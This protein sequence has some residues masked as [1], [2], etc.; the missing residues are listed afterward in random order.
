[1]IQ[2]SIGTADPER[3]IAAQ[4]HYIA[5]FFDLHLKGVQQ[6]LLLSPSEDYPEVQFV[7]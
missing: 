5:S 2:Q 1:M 7:E 3:T 4:R 6:P